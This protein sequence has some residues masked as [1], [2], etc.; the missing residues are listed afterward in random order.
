MIDLSRNRKKAIPIYPKRKGYIPLDVEDFGDGGAFPE[1]HV[2]QYPLN[3]GKPGMKSTAVVA[4]DVDENGQI[5][6]DAIVKQG[7]NR[8]KIVQTSIADMK[9]KKGDAVSLALPSMEEE[10]EVTNKTKLAL[11]ALVQGKIASSKPL[12]VAGHKEAE[13]TYIKYTPNPNAPGYVHS[14]IIINKSNNN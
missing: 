5:R 4:V 8:N 7:T 11:E 1:I 12:D 10:I 2:V 14:H 6:Y 3:M 9:E 13:P